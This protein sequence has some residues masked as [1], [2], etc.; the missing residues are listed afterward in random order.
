[1][2]SES[3]AVLKVYLGANQAGGYL[4]FGHTERMS[5]A[6]GKDAA[7]KLA[8]IQ[9][10]LEI[11]HPPS[12]WSQSDLAGEQRVFEAKLALLFPELDDIAV[13]SLARRWSY[14]WK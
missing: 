12:D 1:M 8:Q 14:S 9:K 3:S 6:Y 10:Y 4:P 2:K 7:T 11:D 13:N 5:V